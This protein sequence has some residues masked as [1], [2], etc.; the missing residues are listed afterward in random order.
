MH[1]SSGNV[2]RFR[3]SKPSDEDLAATVED[4]QAR[5]ELLEHQSCRGPQTKLASSEQVRSQIRARTLR[6]EFFK[7]ELFS[8][9][10]WDMLLE[11]YAAQ[12]EFR[13][14]TVSQLCVASSVPPTTALRWI[15]TMESEGLITRRNDPLD[16]RRVWIDLSETGSEAMR[17]YFETL[18]PVALRL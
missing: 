10:T 16:R 13:R 1:E 3:L 6:Y 2:E 7:W 5:L 12:L 18:S 9:P 15:G 8:D 14:V 4:L 17:R 11:L